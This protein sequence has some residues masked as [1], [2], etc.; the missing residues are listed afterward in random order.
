[1]EYLLVGYTVLGKIFV[2]LELTMNGVGSIVHVS[3]LT[4]SSPHSVHRGFFQY[5]SLALLPLCHMHPLHLST[6]SSDLSS[7]V[8][9]T[10]KPS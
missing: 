5:L 7:N 2:L 10:G 6:L 9:A 3:S 8:P 4:M 1:M